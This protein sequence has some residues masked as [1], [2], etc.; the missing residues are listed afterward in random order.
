MYVTLLPLVA[1]ER[2]GSYLDAS[3]GDVSDAFALYEW[4]MRAAASIM[5]LTSMVEVLARNALDRELRDWAHQRRAGASWLDVVPLAQ[6]G[7]AD[8]QKARDRATRRRRRPKVHGRVVAELSLG[9]W[10]YLVESRYLT[11]L[12][13]PATHRAFPAGNPDFRTRQ[14]DVAFRMQRLTFIRN[15]AA[16]HEPIHSRILGEDLRSAMDLAAWI[17]P[18]AANWVNATS[19]LPLIIWRS[20]RARVLA[21]AVTGPRILKIV[22]SRDRRPSQLPVPVAVDHPF[23][24]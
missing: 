21:R 15:R 2:L 6:Q 8:I 13:V 12:W 20:R 17:S 18:V 19:S 7:A 16:H 4:N 9:F 5:E 11:T 22:R 10:R 24:A 1:A 3:D 23:S 14:E